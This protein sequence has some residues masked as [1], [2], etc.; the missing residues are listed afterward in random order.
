MNISTCV[1]LQPFGFNFTG[2]KLLTKLVF[3]EEVQKIFREKYNNPLL[4]ITTTSLYGKSIQYDRLKEIKL[5]GYTKGNSVY[6]YPKEFVQECNKYLKDYYNITVNKKLYTI[7]RVLQKLEL[8][9]DEFMISN[10]KGIYFGFVY[11]DSKDYLC[12]KINKIKEYKL[13]SINEIFNKWLNRWG[14]QR[15]NNLLNSN[16]IHVLLKNSSLE[17]TKKCL[18]KLKD[19]LGEEEYKKQHNEYMK[20]YRN[21]KKKL[22]EP[23]KNIV[24]KTNNDQLS[25]QPLKQKYTIKPDLPDNFSLYLE[26]EKWYLSF[27]KKINTIRYNKKHVM[28]CMCIQTELNRLINEVN[29]EFTNLNIEKYTVKNPYDFID[30]IPLKENNKPVLPS[31]F[32]ICNVTSKDYIQ[33]TKK[34]NDKKVSYKTVIKSYDLQNELDNFVNYLNDEYKLNLPEQKIIETNNW[35]TTNKIK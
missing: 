23:T 12:N 4:A 2:G 19:K 14:I 20:S 9:K 26:K 29:K 21:K 8:P 28:Q 1:P 15:Y 5:I 32:S 31:S 24:Q 25:T 13:K 10:P 27:S 34:I 22:I 17:R 11:P 18:Q 33:F 16:K 3:S 30:K 7:S 6:K 35:K